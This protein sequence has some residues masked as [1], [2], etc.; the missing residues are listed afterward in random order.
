MERKG[1]SNL[2]R[3][4]FILSLISLISLAS[5]LA[6]LIIGFFLPGF[7]YASGLTTGI[8]FVFLSI[9]GIL[10]SL[11]GSCLGLA[12]ILQKTRV[13]RFAFIGTIISVALL[14]IYIFGGVA[15]ILLI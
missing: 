11:T 12:G 4:S 8:F 7:I 9:I 2:G 3:A 14:C 5:K 6:I 15:T 10:A 1:Q 13:R